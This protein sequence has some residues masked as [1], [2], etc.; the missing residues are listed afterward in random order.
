MNKKVLHTVIDQHG[1]QFPDKLAL[2]EFSGKESTYSQL[3]GE[4][5]L[6]A[7]HLCQLDIVLVL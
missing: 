7:K 3:K 4:S 2:R 6:I 1:L 5:D